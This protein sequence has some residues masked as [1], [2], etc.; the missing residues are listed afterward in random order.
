YGRSKWEMDQRAEQLKD[1]LPIVGLRY[2]NVYGPREEH[3]ERAASMIL[4][5]SRQMREGKRPRLFRHGE[6]KRDFIYVKDVVEANIRAWEGPSGVYNVG[7]GVGSTFNE[8]V[9]CLNR[10]LG[11]DLEPEYFD[12][13]YDP[14]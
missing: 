8:L 7:T 10:S 1:R 2:F 11:T 9:A 14:A 6:Q 5:L 3:K 4:H 12:M 13:P